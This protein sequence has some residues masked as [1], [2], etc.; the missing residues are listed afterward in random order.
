MR[1]EKPG[2]APTRR[3]LI[4]SLLAEPMSAAQI[5]ARSLESIDR[6]APSH[7]FSRQEWEIV[8]RMIHT[9]G[10]FGIM[11][12]IRFSPTAIADATRALNE[13]KPIY[14]DAN[15]I[16]AGL[17]LERL[18]CAHPN[19]AAD[20]IYCSIADPDV[21]SEAN[22]MG[23]PRSIFA[24][25]KVRAVLDGAL[26]VFGNAPVALLELNRM[27]VEEGLRP[28]AV[29][30]MPVGFVHVVESKAELMGLETP[31]IVLE[32]RRGGSPLAVSVVHAL[33]SLAAKGASA[34]RESP[35]D[36]SRA[37]ILFG[38]GSRVPGASDDMEK[39]AMRMR[40]RLGGTLIETCSMSKLGPHFPEI[41]DRCV[42]HGATEILVMPY[43]LH[44]GMHMIEDIPDIL[45]EKVKDH[46]HVKLI[47]GKNLGF[48]E[49]LVE[50]LLRR[51]GESKDLPDVREAAYATERSMGKGHENG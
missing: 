5:E 1:N 30:G 48:D 37:V 19:Y 17:S 11:K 8:R 45:R 28:A 26:C 32:G 20:R 10:D 6:E 18:R 50:L 46:P 40:A 38:H 39:V 21:A 43:F 49:S 12:S 16:R 2:A 31:W 41:F 25:R 4:A 13:G 22:R 14:T 9:T 33:C 42:V 27:I 7:D 35:A 34:R 36:R 44:A 24:V 47:F 51:V 3:P 15:M 29:I 23:L